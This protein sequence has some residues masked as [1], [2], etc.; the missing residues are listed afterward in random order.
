MKNLPAFPASFILLQQEGHLISS[1]LTMGLTQ[2]RSADVHNKGAFY[3]ALF[4]LSIG[5]ERLLK[6]TV[7]IDHMLKHHLA[8]P[9]RKELKGYGHDIEEL[10]TTCAM[11]PYDKGMTL[12]PLAQLNPITRELLALLSA[13]AKATRYHNLD[14]LSASEAGRDPLIHLNDIL[15]SILLVDVSE[16]TRIRISK[17][18]S[19][20]SKAIADNAF[21]I[22]QGLD[23]ELLTTSQ[24]LLLPRLHEQ[25]TKHAVLYMVDFLSPVRDLLSSLCHNGYGS[26]GSA[27]PFPQ[28]HEFLQW[29]NDD[30]GYVLRKKKWP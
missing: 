30:R 14:A 20:T 8:V 23:G 9:T 15:E 25:A 21:T 24:A 10:Y 29:V 13:F 16:A 4:N 19:A 27:P 11:I 17:H 2:L 7:I 1:C 12:P 5:F 26:G 22:M 3:S 18:A 6:A 28:M